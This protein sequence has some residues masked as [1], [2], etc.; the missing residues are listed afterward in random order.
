MSAAVRPSASFLPRSA[1]AALSAWTPSAKSV[2]GGNHQRGVCLLLQDTGISGRGDQIFKGATADAPTRSRCVNGKIGFDCASPL[3]R[4]G[5]K[6]E[7]PR[8]D[9]VATEEG[10]Q[11]KC[12]PAVGREGMKR[13][14]CV[15]NTSLCAREVPD[16]GRFL[17]GEPAKRA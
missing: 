7:Q 4:I 5:A 3:M 2:R 1:P 10:G 14:R 6:L 16:R 15:A 13:P 11:M 9:G 17:Q 8:H 12:R